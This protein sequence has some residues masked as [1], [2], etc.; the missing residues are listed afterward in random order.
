MRELLGQ[1]QTERDNGYIYKNIDDGKRE[2]QMNVYVQAIT[3]VKV[4][5]LTSRTCPDGLIRSYKTIISCFVL[6]WYKSI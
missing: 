2:N 4:K 6:V 1:G 5:L 3:E